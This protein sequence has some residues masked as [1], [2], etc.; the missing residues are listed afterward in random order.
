MQY[1]ETYTTGENGRD[2]IENM[3]SGNGPDIIGA[4]QILIFSVYFFC[5][6]S[7][8][9]THRTHNNVWESGLYLIVLK[10]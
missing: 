4:A 9:D 7:E 5:R 8:R 3:V 1:T 2:A 10:F 6:R